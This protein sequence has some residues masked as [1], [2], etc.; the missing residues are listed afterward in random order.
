LGVQLGRANGVA[1]SSGAAAENSGE[2]CCTDDAA[3]C[4]GATVAVDVDFARE[5]L[6]SSSVTPSDTS[7]G[8]SFKMLFTDSNLG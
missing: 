7:T 1:A 6:K 2:G 4:D 5:K 3:T 8:F